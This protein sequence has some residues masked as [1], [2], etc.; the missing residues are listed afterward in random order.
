MNMKQWEINAIA[1]GIHL[2][3]TTHERVTRI[4]GHCGKYCIDGAPAER[5]DVMRLVFGDEY[6]P[7]LDFA[8]F[9]A[10][11]RRE[12]RWGLEVTVRYGH[13]ADGERVPLTKE[14]VA[15]LRWRQAACLECRLGVPDIH[16]ATRA[17]AALRGDCY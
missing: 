2:T 9:S 17:A 13:T 8:D 12:G 5:E 1:A 14:Q 6:C 3:A 7:P 10:E 16:S 11:T 15:T 4:I